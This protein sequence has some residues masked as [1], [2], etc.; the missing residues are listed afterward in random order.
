MATATTNINTL[1]NGWSYSNEYRLFYR[2]ESD[3]DTFAQWLK[4]AEAIREGTYEP[5]LL[6]DTPPS[7]SDDLI[8]LWAE[9]YDPENMT[10]EE[11]Q[12]FI[13]DLISAGVLQES[14]KSYVRYDP[15]LVAVGSVFDTI[16]SSFYTA[17]KGYFMMQPVTGYNANGSYHS[18]TE[19]GGNARLW[20]EGWKTAY[21]DADG[22]TSDFV[23]RQLSLF[24]KIAWILDRMAEA[25]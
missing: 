25:K 16:G 23:R 19:A 12:A 11:Y 21:G 15:N 8:D 17:Q 9:K 13:D 24:D 3:L 6:P 5:D 2:N 1:Q 7:I 4:K 20:A 22:Y 10:Q 14:D 18:L